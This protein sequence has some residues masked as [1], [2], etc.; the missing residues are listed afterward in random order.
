M[1]VFYKNFLNQSLSVATTNFEAIDMSQY[2]AVAYQ[3]NTPAAAAG[4]V[5][6]QWSNDGVNWINLGSVA[7]AASTTVGGQISTVYG[8][9]I[10]VQMIVS[11]GAGVYSIFLTLKEN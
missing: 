2:T 1:K 4:T 3:V 11:A 5:Q 8:A 10:R 7:L 6:I 9:L